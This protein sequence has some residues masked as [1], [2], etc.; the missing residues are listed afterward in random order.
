MFRTESRHHRSEAPDIA[1]LFFKPDPAQALVDFRDG[2]WQ[3][4]ARTM[5][6][7][8]QEASLGHAMAS[9]VKA[10]QRWQIAAFGTIM[11]RAS[12]P[13]QASEWVR[14]DVSARIK[15]LIAAGVT[16]GKI[17]LPLDFDN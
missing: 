16:A 9:S 8:E 10:G 3:N 15:A 12:A 13:A 5:L 6:G 2:E 4:P 7:S 11:G 1:P 14:P 17:G